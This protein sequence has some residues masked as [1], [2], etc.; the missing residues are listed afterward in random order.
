MISGLKLKIL[1]ILQNKNILNGGLYTVFAFIRQ[2]FNFVMLLIVSAY[3]APAEYGQLSLF[4]SCVQVFGFFLGFSCSGYFSVSFF[5]S[6][7][8]EFHNDVGV[9][10]LLYL[11]TAIIGLCIVGALKGYIG[12][13]LGIPPEMLWLVVIISYFA[14]QYD[15]LLNF[16]RINEKVY[17]YGII[18][19][20][21]VLIY[22]SL[23][24]FFVIFQNQNWMGVVF[25]NTIANVS[26]GT[27]A[28]I[29]IFKSG[30]VSFHFTRAR[31]KSILL[32][33][34]PLIPHLTSSWICNGCDQY[35]VKHFYSTYE[36]G[37]FSFALNLSSVIAVVGTAFNMTYSVNI[38][39]TLSSCKKAEV[40]IKTRLQERTLY[41][42]NI[43]STFLLLV[44]LSL[45]VLLF[46]PNYMPSLPYFFILV[47]FS[48]LQC[49]YLIYC[50]YLFYY[51]ATKKLMYITFGSSI[52]HLLLSIWLTRYNLYLTA[53]IYIVVQAGVVILISS[54]SKR[55]LGKNINN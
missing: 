34:L 52:I 25:A 19:L 23:S 54:E 28:L 30:I 39:Q 44:G 10:F 42:I 20:V 14:S 49:V 15:I 3:I 27:A 16:F 11:L 32:W 51:G 35:I 33:S 38:Y 13:A 48:F 47:L 41:F 22:F 18:A 31:V 55:L 4:N 24:L 5:K 46:L 1:A 8:K 26:L 36:V 21:F 53:I 45:I 9:I 12:T 43:A 2:G 50:N 7:R 37:I 6:E 40:I 17:K 29:F